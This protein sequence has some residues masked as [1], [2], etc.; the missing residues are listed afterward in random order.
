LSHNTTPWTSFAFHPVEALVQVGFIGVVF[1]FPV[2]TLALALVMTWQML[3]NVIG[4]L[5]Y[6]LIP[7]KLYHS[8]LGKWMNT[9]TH[10]NMHHRYTNSNYGLY[11][12]VWDTFMNTNHPHY[13]QQ[14][15]ESAHKMYSGSEKLKVD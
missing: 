9:S 2:H 12:N 10:H 1:L 15:L 4:H 8:F 3:F 7:T 14:Y 13:E 6:E 11:F 5:G